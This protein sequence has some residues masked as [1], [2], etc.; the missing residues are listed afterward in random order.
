MDR[1]SAAM[2]KVVNVKIY[3]FKRAD[4]ANQKVAG[5]WACSLCGSHT[6]TLTA[7]GS[8][9]CAECGE[10]A[11]NLRAVELGATARAAV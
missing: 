10:A 3:R 7:G 11:A 5:M 9:C 4:A 1:G 8:A 6:W 2:G